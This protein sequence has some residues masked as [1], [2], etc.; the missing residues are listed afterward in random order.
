MPTITM[1]CAAKNSTTPESTPMAKNNA[2][3]MAAITTPI[4]TSTLAP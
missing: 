4:H 2:P 3:P 1:M